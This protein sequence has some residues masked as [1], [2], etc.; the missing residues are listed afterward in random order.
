[1]V[2]IVALGAAAAILAPQFMGLAPALGLFNRIERRGGFEND[3]RRKIFDR[4]RDMPGSCI[5]DIATTVGVSH[6][7]ASYHLDKLVEFNLVTSTPDGNKVRYFANGGVFT[8]EERRILS[9][10][11]H[12]ETRRV[13]AMIT[14]NPH[15]YR[16]E[17]TALLGVSPP[18]VSWHLERLT[19]AALVSEQRVGRSRQLFV[20]KKRLERLL[21][22]LL[23][24]LKGTGYDAKGLQDLVLEC[25]IST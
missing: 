23:D 14:K 4:V 21:R 7:T 15:S 2:V 25:A 16:A 24:K 13:L 18:T 5:A 11:Q 1:M 9:A 19:G 20:D 17:L 6:S 3:T 8:E 10:L 22:L 12:P